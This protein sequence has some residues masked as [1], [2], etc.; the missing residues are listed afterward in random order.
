MNIK[1]LTEL[2]NEL[3]ALMEKFIVIGYKLDFDIDEDLSDESFAWI[4]W[5]TIDL[6]IADKIIN[7]ELKI[8]YAKYKELIC[9]LQKEIR[10][11][12]EFIKEIE[13]EYEY[14]KLQDEDYDEDEFEESSCYDKDDYCRAYFSNKENTS[15][16]S[17]DYVKSIN[18]NKKD[19]NNNSN[20]DYVKSISSKKNTNN[21]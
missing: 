20:Y 12:N 18:I 13:K 16:N 19:N 14:S 1:L 5:A 21:F 15:D 3:K 11:F 9:N 6:T 8:P 7:D 17:Y 4:S 2:R 10:M